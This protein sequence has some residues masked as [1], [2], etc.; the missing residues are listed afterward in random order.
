[1]AATIT[2]KGVTLTTVSDA[3]KKLL[4][5]GKYMEDDVTITDATDGEL[6]VRIAKMNY[7]FSS[8]GLSW[9]SLAEESI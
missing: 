2:Y 7:V 9:S 8:L 1:M 6:P 3:T 5:A 4:T